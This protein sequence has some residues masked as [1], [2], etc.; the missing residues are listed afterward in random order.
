MP[1][2]L[3]LTAARKADPNA[4]LCYNDYG[5]GGNNSK[6]DRMVELVADMKIR[7]VTINCCRWCWCWWCWC[8]CCCRCCCC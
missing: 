3:A 6:T 4:V 1:L 8:W 5:V 2:I 7:K